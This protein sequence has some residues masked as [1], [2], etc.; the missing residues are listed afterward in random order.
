MLYFGIFQFIICS[1]FLETASL[2][3]EL[4]EVCF[5]ISKF[6]QIFLFVFLL[7]IA[8]IIP[9]KVKICFMTQ[10]MICLGE[11]RKFIGDQIRLAIKWKYS[12]CSS[13]PIIF[14]ILSSSAFLNIARDSVKTCNDLQVVKLLIP[15]NFY[16]LKELKMVYL[17][18]YV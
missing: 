3:Y 10:D 8:S 17:W 4:L 1:D 12:F 13:A 16:V 2:T 11:I 15:F 5:L 14:L 6:F 18:K 7:L 9:F